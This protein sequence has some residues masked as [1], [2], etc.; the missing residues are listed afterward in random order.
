MDARKRIYKIYILRRNV[1]ITHL[2]RRNP[3]FRSSPSVLS[4]FSSRHVSARSLS[5]AVLAP[6]PHFAH[7]SSFSPSL[8]PASPFYERV[9]RSV[10][11]DAA[12]MRQLLL[13][14]ATRRLKWGGYQ[15]CP[16]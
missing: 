7:F 16:L 15:S 13:D 2:S 4:F 9:A 14:K 10:V 11:L 1:S 3:D 8:V 5:P 12:R 6:P